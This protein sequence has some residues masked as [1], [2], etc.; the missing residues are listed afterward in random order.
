MGAGVA[1]RSHFLALYLLV[2]VLLLGICAGGY[3]RRRN[4]SRYE[5]EPELWT[6]LSLDQALLR[7]HS[8]VGLLVVAHTDPYGRLQRSICLALHVVLQLL[9]AAVLP[10]LGTGSTGSA[11]TSEAVLS[12][13][14]SAVVTFVLSLLVAEPFIRRGAMSRN[15]L[16]RKL[17]VSFGLG[18]IVLVL[19]VLSA[20][21]VIAQRTRLI[22]L[23]YRTVLVSF[24][25]A[26]VLSLFV[27]E[28][29][30]A[31]FAF[32]VLGKTHQATRIKAT[33][34]GV[35]DNAISGAEGRSS[36]SEVQSLS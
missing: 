19:A 27:I 8:V 29:L 18:A 14:L 25:A 7:W 1:T 35:T 21:A 10:L 31:A 13:L 28:P 23:H 15:P 20:L 2:G 26:Q 22:A 12:G 5:A 33:A 16:A 3:A 4:A 9:V 34:V 36:G 6:R 32:V 30:M 11:T 24:S 17:A